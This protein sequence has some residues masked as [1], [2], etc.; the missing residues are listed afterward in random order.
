MEL[1]EKLFHWAWKTKRKFSKIKVSQNACLLADVQTR[2]TMLATALRGEIVYAKTAEHSGGYIGQSLFLPEYID[3]SDSKK[4][5]YD[6]FMARLVIDEL[7]LEKGYIFKPEVLNHD[8]HILL[9]LILFPTLIELAKTSSCLIHDLLEKEKKNIITNIKRNKKDEIFFQHWQR[10]IIDPSF[11]GK[12]NDLSE[13][14]IKLIKELISIN[15]LSPSDLINTTVKYKKILKDHNLI[16]DNKTT[17]TTFI[18]KVP[19]GSQ[20]LFINNKNNS[21]TTSRESNKAETFKKSKP[22]EKVKKVI[23]DEENP[24]CNPATLLMESVKTAD[25]FSGGNKMIDGSDELNE[26]MDAIED[27]DIREIT[28]SSTQANSVFKADISIDTIVEFNEENI[29]S[30]SRVFQYDEWNHLKKSYSKNWC[31]LVE[32]VL[33]TLTT[34]EAIDDYASY[35]KNLL[36]KNNK[37]IKHL[38]NHLK[39]ILIERSPRNR[40]ID[41]SELDLDAVINRHTDIISGYN[42][43]EK[44]YISPRKAKSDLSVIIL[45]DSS[46]S[47]DSWVNGHRVMDIAKESLIVIETVLDDII[48]NTMIASFFSNTRKDCQFNIVKD[49]SDNWKNVNSRVG[50]LQPTG[51]TRIGASLRHS[52]EKFEKINSKKKIILLLSDGKPTDYDA[53]E[54]KYGIADVRQC[55]REAKAKN[56]DIFS[57][58]IDKDAKFYFPQLFGRKNYQILSDPEMLSDQI[59]NLFSKLLH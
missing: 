5:N 49:F 35:Y 48:D 59:I 55:V 29:A 33:P 7:A 52:V 17:L 23:L 47:S 10:C 45:L 43:S 11:L 21:T 41:G 15:K 53:Y 28:R 30:T 2:L 58:A 16:L 12:I 26:H 22:K 57:L 3:I 51:Y 31:S 42:P 40:Q 54:G 8:D 19:T 18:S 32:N 4:T 14:K 34:P 9:S 20:K 56:I 1:D 24:D 39:N 25:I 50:Q 44:I 37:K 6:L 36:I 38:K 13:R 46:L 27:L